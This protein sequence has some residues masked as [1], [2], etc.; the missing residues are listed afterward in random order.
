KVSFFIRTAAVNTRVG[1]SPS[2]PGPTVSCCRSAGKVSVGTTPW[3]SPSSPPSNGSS[4]T[5]GPGRRGR[6]STVPSSTTSRAGTTP[7]GCTRPSATSAPTSTK[8]DCS[9]PT[10]R[11][12]D[13]L[14]KPVRET[15]TS[16]DPWV[17]WIRRMPA[18]QKAGVVLFAVGIGLTVVLALVSGAKQAPSQGTDVLLVLLIALTQGGA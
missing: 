13:Q 8:H 16:P 11:Q 17:A 1:T 3:P 14:K 9:T 10:V 18:R 15:G 5:I 2:W 7:A 6:Y 4:S 12:H